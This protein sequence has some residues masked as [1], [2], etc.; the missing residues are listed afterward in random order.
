MIQ[1]VKKIL[2]PIDFSE[3][4]LQAMRGAWELARDVGAELHLLHVVVPQSIFA[5]LPLMRDA[6]TARE[7]AREAAM[8]QQAEEEMARIR[9]DQLENSAKV[10]T[11]AVAGSPVQKI[12]DYAGEQN[13]DLILC[14]SHGRTG[15]SAIVIGSVTEKLVR[16]AP[17]SILVLRAR[18]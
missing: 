8:V 9:K 7:M 2:S 13:I 16:L 12:V 4:S 17:C 1:R 10:V 18:N 15:L 5:P 3:F 11:A 14:S 6:E